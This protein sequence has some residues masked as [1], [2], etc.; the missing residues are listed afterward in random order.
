MQRIQG[1]NFQPTEQYSK[2]FNSQAI[3]LAVIYTLFNNQP[4]LSEYWVKHDTVFNGDCGLQ[5]VAAAINWPLE[6]LD[7]LRELMVDLIVHANIMTTDNSSDEEKINAMLN[8]FNN[9]LESFKQYFLNIIADVLVDESPESTPELKINQTIIMDIIQSIKF[10]EDIFASSML[11]K[12]ILKTGID[13]EYRLIAE[14]HPYGAVL[15]HLKAHMS[16]PGSWLPLDAIKLL[17]LYHGYYTK[18]AEYCKIGRY[19]ELTNQVVCFKRITDETTNIYIINI[20]QSSLKPGGIHWA[21]GTKNENESGVTKERIRLKTNI[22]NIKSRAQNFNMMDL[23]DD[24]LLLD[25]TTSYS[26]ILEILG[27]ETDSD[28]KILNK[29]EPLFTKFLNSGFEDDDFDN[30]LLMCPYVCHNSADLL[31]NYLESFISIIGATNL[32]SMEVENKLKK[33]K[34]RHEVITAPDI[35][36]ILETSKEPLY[37][38]EGLHLSKKEWHSFIYFVAQTFRS[39]DFHEI[40]VQ[41]ATLIYS[42]GDSSKKNIRICIETTKALITKL[43]PLGFSQDALFI[44]LEDL[45]GKTF[46]TKMKELAVLSEHSDVIAEMLKTYGIDSVIVMKLLYQ[47]RHKQNLID[48]AKNLK[49]IDQIISTLLE[50]YRQEYPKAKIEKEEFAN[51]ILQQVLY[52]VEDHEEQFQKMSTASTI[53]TILTTKSKSIM[54]AEIYAQDDFTIKNIIE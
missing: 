10:K 11:V 14:E 35:M 19:I 41:L 33:K 7:R 40:G 45:D 38:L 8:I 54:F 3:A 23:E 25:N 51:Q 32:Q 43:H 13:I 18:T 24:E 28:N 49:A 44:L 31:Y 20:G 16:T 34:K 9:D 1:S 37:A 36:R 2:N 47:K 27:I 29:F 6:Q 4:N 12:H 5:A 53:I 26:T 21:C 22:V 42:S 48:L 30:L 46:L 39:S 52:T 17:M 50:E 15:A